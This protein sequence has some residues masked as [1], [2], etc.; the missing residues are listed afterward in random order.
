MENLND[1]WPI[2]AIET[3]L[4]AEHERRFD[5]D[6]YGIAIATAPLAGGRVRVSGFY[7]VSLR[8]AADLDFQGRALVT[9]VEEHRAE[10]RDLALV[11]EVLPDLDVEQRAL[12]AARR[13]GGV[14]EVRGDPPE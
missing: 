10:Q 9:A 13:E 11:A 1:P 6:A 4:E 7:V 8:T 3:S 2:D 5:A 12:L 14:G